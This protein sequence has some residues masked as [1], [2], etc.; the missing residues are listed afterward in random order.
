VVC[1]DCGTKAAAIF[2]RRSGGLEGDLALCEAC[3]RA[4][5]VVVGPGG[6]DLRL[7]GLLAAA[8]SARGAAAKGGLDAAAQAASRIA[9]PGC[10]I[11]LSVIAREGRL[12]C[13]RCLEAFRPQIAR[14][15]ASRDAARP[16]AP[17]AT[18][19]AGGLEGA[20]SAGGA[21]R[22]GPA[23]PA[24]SS[25]LV[26]ALAEEDYEKAARIRDA[27][28]RGGGERR[29]SVPMPD[30]SLPFPLRLPA[31]DP[32]RPSERSG[33]EEDVVLQT[34]VRV[35]R[36]FSDLPF[37]GSPSGGISPSRG[38]AVALFSAMRS[39]EVHAMAD[40]S[41]AAR[42]ALAELAVLPR[43]YV[44][45]EEATFAANSDSPLYALEDE[46]D[47]V[48]VVARLPGLEPDRAASIALGAAERVAEGGSAG[49]ARDEEFGWLCAR[50]ED[51]GPGLSIAALVHLPALSMAGM[52]D[53]LFRR[54]MADGIQVRGL[55]AGVYA[56]ADQ[57]ESASAGALYEL[58]ATGA[59]GTDA[60]AL[61]ASIAKASLLAARA[62]RRAR[63]EIAHRDPEAVA[64]AAGR[65][66]GILSHCRRIGREE[67]AEHLSALRLSALSGSLEGIDARSLGALMGRL[68]PGTMA[69][70]SG[71]AAAPAEADRASLR[72]AFLRGT[73][74]VAS[75]VEEG[76]RCSRD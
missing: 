35:S 54:L 51:C 62:E 1:V 25:E 48:S 21:V 57:D 44:S 59:T 67:A 26:R 47:H 69:V 34:R 46:T 16:S 39:W 12:G 20:G 31:F 13:A 27:A 30:G 43:S 18:P 61:A 66:F 74:A 3:A 38:R 58:V 5:G 70:A 37:P 52:R 4:R 10:G 9:C 56:G 36:N 19:P 76:N 23:I 24:V 65:A 41:P 63:A 55:Y 73:V 8:F 15:L 64:D 22:E 14:L 40:I 72:A 28:A 33:P 17:L 32:A 53:R 71:M 50:L 45:D 68:G 75:I 2:I 7:D 11:E 42:L 6:L 60:Q 49:F 29:A